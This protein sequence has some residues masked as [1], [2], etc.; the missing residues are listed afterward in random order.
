MRRQRLVDLLADA[1]RTQSE[2]V[3]ESDASQPTVSRA[4]AELRS[5]DLVRDRDGEYDLT[6]LGRLVLSRYRACV[7]E[8]GDACAARDV[9]RALPEDAPDELFLGGATVRSTTARAPDNAIGPLTRVPADATRLRA[10]ASV[11]WTTLAQ[12]VVDR[13]VEDGLEAEVVLAAD[14]LD[15]DTPVSVDL[16]RAHETGRLALYAADHARPYDFSITETPSETYVGLIARGESG[17]W[18]TVVTA[19]DEAVAWAE[20]QFERIKA[21][22]ERWS[23]VATDAGADA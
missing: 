19:S 3:A 13:I 9:V 12:R 8:I 10:C 22:G 23:P 5:R 18:S 2:L 15:G 14:L 4:V 11:V 17:G 21:S 1:P 6:R 16:T 7:S 20:R